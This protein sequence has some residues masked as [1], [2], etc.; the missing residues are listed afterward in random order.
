MKKLLSKINR[1]FQDFMRPKRLALGK[2][3]WDRKKS[4]LKNRVAI[5]D[6]KNIIE[7]LS[8]KSV[9]FLRGDGKIGDMVINSL[10]FRELKKT[11]PELTIGVVVKGGAKDI[12]SN[13][14]HIDH[15]YDYSS[16]SSKVKKL[17]QHIETAGYDLVIDFT[18]MLRVKQMMFINLCTAKYNLGINKQDWNLFDLTINYQ[19]KDLHISAKYAAILKVLG[20]AKPNL[21]YDIHIDKQSVKQTEV[22]LEQ[23]KESKLVII[24]PYGASKHRTLTIETVKKIVDGLIKIEDWAIS[25]VFPPEKKSEI[26]ALCDSYQSKVYINEQLKGIQ[27]TACLIKSADYVITPDTSIVHLA[28]AFE[29]PMLAIYRR[30]LGNNAKLWG[31]GCSKVKQFFS[32]PNNNIAEESDINNLDMGKLLVELSKVADHSCI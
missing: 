11:Y 5:I 27:D 21:S 6:R 29:R 2:W 26:K 7:E 15:I 8:I 17:A 18:E 13:N 3:R 24:N 20:I 19:D 32:Q 28:V 14:P 9:L 31:P 1:M 12:I 10:M 23:V 4:H 30:E 22:F 25:F 16:S